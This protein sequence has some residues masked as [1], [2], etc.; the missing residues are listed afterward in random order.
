MLL[1]VDDVWETA[2]GNYFLVGGPSC[3]T[4]FTTRESPIAHALATR[5]STVKVDLLS[6][7]DA[8]AMLRSLVPE[9]ATGDQQ[10][11]FSLCQRLE[12]LPLALTLAGGLLANLADIP[13]AMQRLLDE[14]IEHR[15]ARLHLLKQHGRLGLDEDA[16]VS[17]HAIL[18]MSVER[19]D[20]I[21]QERFAMLSVF[22]AE[23]LTWQLDAVA[24]VWECS[25]VEAEKTILRLIQRGIIGVRDSSFWMH[26][27][28]ADYA[29][30]LCESMGL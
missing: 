7:T 24:H 9:I 22:G 1:L 11:V 29:A 8:V 19:L 23:P 2:H 13:T 15:A 16:P 6:P 30:E 28:L 25:E 20:P 26:A 18:G 14:L 5:A 12:Y 17:L 3:R 4:L 10:L 21:E 27:L